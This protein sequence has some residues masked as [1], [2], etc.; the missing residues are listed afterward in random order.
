[1]TWGANTRGS[2]VNIGQH[3]QE[4]ALIAIKGVDPFAPMLQAYRLG[5]SAIAD[6][7]TSG[8]KENP[9]GCDLPWVTKQ[10]I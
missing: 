10:N 9:K 7:M 3:L 1:M 6:T 2:E 5:E 8:Q 4:A